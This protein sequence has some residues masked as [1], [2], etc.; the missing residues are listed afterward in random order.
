[1]N[2]L[3]QKIVKTRKEHECFACTRSFAKDS[4]MELQV[5]TDCSGIWSVY[6]FE[7]CQVLLKKFGDLFE[8]DGCF[9]YACVNE[10]MSYVEFKSETP[11]DFLKELIEQKEEK[12]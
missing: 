2:L 1:M 9:P 10:G 7:T 8:F 11:E 12:C 6:V 4:K 5:L 3:E